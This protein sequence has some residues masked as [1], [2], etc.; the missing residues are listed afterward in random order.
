MKAPESVLQVLPLSAPADRPALPFPKRATVAELRRRRDRHFRDGRHD[1]ALQM[2]TEVAARDPGRESYLKQGMLLQQVGRYREALGVL[3]DALRFETGPAYLLPDIHLHLA[4]TWFVVGKR[5]RMSESLKRAQALRLK[6]RTAFN[7]HMSCGN[8]LLSKKDFRGALLEYLQ[9]EKCAPN[10]MGRGRAAVNQGIALIRQWDF[11][12]AQ[13]PLD[14]ALRI[15]KRAGH[16]AELAI[17][18]SVRAAVYSERG[19]HQRALTMFLHAGRSFRRLG[20]IDREAEVLANAAFNAGAVGQWSKARVI[21]DRAIGLGAVTG[22][23]AVL[24]VA[25][26]VR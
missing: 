17:A 8:F 4:Y 6:P 20:K 5:K 10:A 24:S 15:L 22:Q 1:L 2:A 12:A 11:A 7:F 25:Y 21:A 3:R 9:A 16:A 18:R 26:G 19:Q 14:R 23:D 13:G